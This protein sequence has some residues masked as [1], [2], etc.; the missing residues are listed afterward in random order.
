MDSTK[1]W[2]ASKAV[3]GGIIAAGAAIAGLFHISVSAADQASLMDDAVTIAGG[4]G[5]VLAIVGRIVAN[6]KI[7]K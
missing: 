1:S 7:T 5:G 4:V 6:A 2:Y 3:W